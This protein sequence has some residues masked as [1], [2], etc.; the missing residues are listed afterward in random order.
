MY[1]CTT[2]NSFNGLFCSSMIAKR[3]QMSVDCVKDRLLYML[4]NGAYHMK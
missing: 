1:F 4:T 2:E 3:I